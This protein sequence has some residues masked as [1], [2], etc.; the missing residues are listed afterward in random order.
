MNRPA[1]KGW[2]PGALRPMMSG[3]GLLVRVRPRLGRLTAEEIEALCATANAHGN[4]VIDLTSRGNIQV[5]GVSEH[6]YDRLLIEL[7]AAELIDQSAADE[8][9]NNII[10]SPLWQ[11]GDDTE[12]VAIELGARLSELPD[13]PSKFGFA[14]DAGVL[15]ML[16]AASADIRV[17]RGVS[18]EL[19]VRPDGVAVGGKVPLD[20]V[21]DRVI[22]LCHWFV[23]TGGEQSK[24]M[25]RHV[26]K[27]SFAGET[28]MEAPATAAPQLV[29]GS[30]SLGPVYGVPFGSMTATNLM[31]IVRSSGADALRTTPWR[32]FV[33]E[34]GQ[35]V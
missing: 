15:P 18:S 20:R 23:E 19:I 12:R 8:E 35:A 2:C 34:V 14:I 11:T 17:E 28:A 27:H 3:D 13:L 5:R 33:L 21:V 24:R 26:S 31:A 30:S 4:G 9:R 29:P 16:S 22:A 32:L 6:T 1:A 10:T 7:E 25:V